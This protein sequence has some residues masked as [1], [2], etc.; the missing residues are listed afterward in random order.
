MACQSDTNTNTDTDTEVG[1]EVGNETSKGSVDPVG[2]AEPV[3]AFDESY[4]V[5]LADDRRS[6]LV[7]HYNDARGQGFVDAIWFRIDKDTQIVTSNEIPKESSLDVADLQLGQ[8]VRVWHRGEIAESYP[9]QGQATKIEV[10]PP[11]DEALTKA[12]GLQTVIAMAQRSNPNDVSAWAIR[13]IRFDQEYELWNVELV[14]A[15]NLESPYTGQIDAKSGSFIV[16]ENE[17]FRIFA[18]EKNSVVDSAF[19]VRGSARVF[20]ATLQWRL[21]DG[22]NVLAEGFATAQDGA[23]AWG[24]FEFTVE[25]EQATSPVLILAL[26]ESSPEDGQPI[27]QLL[28]PLKVSKF[29]D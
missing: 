1:T 21:E 6:V 24:L 3:L 16:A 5:G 10:L 23:P 28:L 20:E 7:T 18:P 12:N 4:I 17:A 25:F 9:A 13:S 11:I 2:T 26:Y 14:N 22:H 8:R 27:H 29:G 19:T 15:Q